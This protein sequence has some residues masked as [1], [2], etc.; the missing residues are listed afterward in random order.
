[1]AEI[2]EFAVSGMPH[3]Y[4]TDDC[5]R[6]ELTFEDDESRQIKLLF[7]AQRF[8]ELSSRA[9]Q[10][11]THARNERLTK[12]DHLAIHAVEVVAAMAETATGGGKVILGLRGDSGL[13]FHFALQ[14]EEAERLRP[15]LHRA[16]T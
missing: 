16:A 12:G 2:E 13:L 10:L 8:E 14:P 7:D 15:Q 5:S 11:F 9:I 1:M 6:I 4:V 3:A